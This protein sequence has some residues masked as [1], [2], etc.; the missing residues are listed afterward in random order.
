MSFHEK[1]CSSLAKKGKNYFFFAVFF[2]AVFFLAA[3]FFGAF[4]LA[5]FLAAFFLG[6]FFL[7]AFLA[8]FFLAAA[9]FFLA[10]FFPPL[11]RKHRKR[12]GLG[13]QQ[14]HVDVNPFS[15]I[16]KI[17]VSHDQCGG[18]R[19]SMIEETE[20]T[21]VLA[22]YLYERIRLLQHLFNKK[23]TYF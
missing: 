19:V 18:H 22:S 9:F 3:F 10:T 16:K 8:T 21:Y 20:I 13:R 14:P 17:T 2:L 4:F 5:T 6:A 11:K 12:D 1:A 7:A 23:C 15:K